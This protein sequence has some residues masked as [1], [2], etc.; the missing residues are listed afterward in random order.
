MY[1]T[2]SIVI[3]NKKKAV[4]Q[5]TWLNN[6]PME[7]EFLIYYKHVTSGLMVM[8]F[9]QLLLYRLSIMSHS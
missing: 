7:T 5:S 1:F 9:L 3:I 2:Y 8:Q 4:I 6:N